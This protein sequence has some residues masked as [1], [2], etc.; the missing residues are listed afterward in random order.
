MLA[1][2]ALA[3]TLERRATVTQA[4]AKSGDPWSPWSSVDG[5]R[6][7]DQ[8]WDDVTWWLFELT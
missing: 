3:V 4:T 5:W 7:N 1:L 2:A 8:G 6:L